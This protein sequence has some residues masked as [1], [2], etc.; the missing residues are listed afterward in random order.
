MLCVA[1]KVT[2]LADELD[3]TST[4]DG[5]G[6]QAHSATAVLLES[7]D[8]I[9]PDAVSETHVQEELILE[10]TGPQAE[11][12]DLGAEPAD[13]EVGDAEVTFGFGF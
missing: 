1:L 9:P 11:M 13:E 2:L 5:D 8:A 12:E 7:S 4:P 3:T 6:N 10:P